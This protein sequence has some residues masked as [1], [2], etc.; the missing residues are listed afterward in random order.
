[1]MTK[2][3]TNVYQRAT[4]HELSVDDCGSGNKETTDAHLFLGGIVISQIGAYYNEPA[5]TEFK[6]DGVSYVFGCTEAFRTPSQCGGEGSWG[7]VRRKMDGDRTTTTQWN[8]HPQ[9]A[10]TYHRMPGLYVGHYYSKEYAP[11][12][13]IADSIERVIRAASYVNGAVC[14][15]ITKDS[16]YY[17]LYFILTFA[18]TLQSEWAYEQDHV[19]SISDPIAYAKEPPKHSYFDGVAAWLPTEEAD[20]GDLRHYLYMEPFHC[21][22]YGEPWH[23]TLAREW[24]R[25]AGVPEEMLERVTLNTLF[26]RA[27]D[28]RPVFMSSNMGTE[29]S[30]TADVIDVL[31]EYRYVLG[32]E[33][34]VHIMAPPLMATN[35]NEEDHIIQGLMITKPPITSGSAYT[36][37]YT[38]PMCDEGY[39]C[40]EEE[41]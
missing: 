40:G 11:L 2:I 19:L 37:D 35:P 25:T 9:Q 28:T 10:T 7:L 13:V 18:A 3:T 30:D 6:V 32:N 38:T 14:W 39:D 26:E 24:Q 8:T 27:P 17:R 20:N 36:R 22:W 33:Y 1:M 29:R 12:A 41:W 31:T 4:I 16:N 34:G 15:A 23:G 21:Q 5:H